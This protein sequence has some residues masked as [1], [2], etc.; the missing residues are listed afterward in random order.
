MAE[1]LHQEIS[2]LT[3]EEEVELLETPLEVSSPVRMHW[4]LPS[5]HSK[6][7]FYAIHH[8]AS[9]EYVEEMLSHK[10]SDYTKFLNTLD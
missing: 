2:S 3:E 10:P 6:L 4:R 1:D 5:R 7:A 8:G 9:P